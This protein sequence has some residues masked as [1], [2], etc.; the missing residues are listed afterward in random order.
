M[1]ASY[2]LRSCVTSAT[3]RPSQVNVNVRPGTQHCNERTVWISRRPAARRLRLCLACWRTALWSAPSKEDTM[4]EA[5]L[6]PNMPDWHGQA[7]KPLSRKRRDGGTHVQDRRAGTG[8]DH[9]AGAPLDHDRAQIGRQVH[10]A[11]VLRDGRRQLHHRR[12]KGRRAGTPRMVSQYPR[13]PGCRGASRDQE[14]EGAGED[15]RRAKNAADFGKRRSNSGR[16]MPTMRSRPNAR[17]LWSCWTLFTKLN[18]T[19]CGRGNVLTPSAARADF[20][21]WRS[22]AQQLAA[23]AH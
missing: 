17:S 3:R 20:F 22:A 13:E 14:G 7:Y 21:H 1:T 15:R 10:I 11:A 19:L 9:G 6:A 18:A 5:K 23:A 8:R 2:R 4:A 12:V 16:L